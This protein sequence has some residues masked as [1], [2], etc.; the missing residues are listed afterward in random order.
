MLIVDGDALA[1][2]LVREQPAD[3][4]VTD[5]DIVAR[6]SAAVAAL[7]IGLHRQAPRSS[8]VFDGSV[9]AAA[10][11][12]VLADPLHEPRVLVTAPGVEVT[13]AVGALIGRHQVGS[14]VLAHEAVATSGV[15]AAQYRLAVDALAAALRSQD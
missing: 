15:V 10:P 4:P 5:G 14:V 3:A 2:A 8:I 9:S 13:T 11:D 12:D 1:A 6:R 7:R